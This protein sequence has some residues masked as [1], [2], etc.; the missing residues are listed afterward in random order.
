MSPGTPRTL[1][2]KEP[3]FFLS[4]VILDESEQA[5]IISGTREVRNMIIISLRLVI[6]R[7]P[8]YYAEIFSAATRTH[9]RCR[10][11]VQIV[12]D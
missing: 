12:K 10:P 4:P 9:A 7:F 6:L 1:A 2:C 8:F 3:C 5:E 11:N